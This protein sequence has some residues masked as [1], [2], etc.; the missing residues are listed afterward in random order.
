MKITDKDN[1]RK[2]LLRIKGEQNLV[3]KEKMTEFEE[4]VDIK[5]KES[6]DNMVQIQTNFTLQRRE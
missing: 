6:I 2:N 5:Y 3:G 1:M 4:E